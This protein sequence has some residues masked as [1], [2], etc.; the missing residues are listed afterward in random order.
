[1]LLEEECCLFSLVKKRDGKE[2]GG[3][4]VRGEG[5]V[6]KRLF[7]GD[8]GAQLGGCLLPIVVVLLEAE[9]EFAVS[10]QIDER[11]F[12]VNGVMGIVE[13]MLSNVPFPLVAFSC[14]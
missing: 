8:H 1:M 4:I 6:S 14:S 9:F 2:K 3:T 7:G 13:Q 10:L 5:G 12:A 11:G